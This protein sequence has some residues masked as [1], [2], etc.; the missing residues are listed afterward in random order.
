[1]GSIDVHH[2]IQPPEYVSAVGSAAIAG[3]AVGSTVGWS[4]E[5]S[6]EA[7][8]ANGI[9]SAV[10]SISAPGVWAGD[11]AAT[12]RLAR[13]CNEFAAQLC[14]DHPGRFGWLAALPLPD[15]AAAIDETT[16]AFDAL[17]ADGAL[18]M[19]NYEN[20]YLGDPRLEPLLAELDRREAVVA[21]HPTLC[22]CLDAVPEIPRSVIEFPHDTTR[23]VCSLLFSGALRKY[24]GIRWLLPHGGGTLAFLAHRIAGVLQLRP[25]LHERL[26]EG[27]IAA[28]QTLYYDTAFAINPPS[29]AALRALVPRSHIVFGTDF[30]FAPEAFTAASVAGLAEVTNDP[31]ELEAVTW[32]NALALF[33][34]FAR[35]IGVS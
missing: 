5:R 22:D 12:T 26:P 23:T 30:P 24:P 4:A 34:R 19:T 18:L 6:L 29:F 17:G 27:V 33:P 16:R 3:P 14:A 2:H 8:D 32:R 13:A 7:M 10:V 35:S 1:M 15:L 9:D 28:L 11:Q 21:L 20:R 31:D 25:D